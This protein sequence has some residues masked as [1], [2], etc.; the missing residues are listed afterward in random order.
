[1]RRLCSVPPLLAALSIRFLCLHFHFYGRA[2]WG[3]LTV[4]QWLKCH[5]QQ[6][7]GFLYWPSCMQ[8][9][10]HSIEAARTPSSLLPRNEM[11]R[12]SAALRPRGGA[13]HPPDGTVCV[14]LTLPR[15]VCASV[16]PA[17]YGSIC[18]HML[19]AKSRSGLPELIITFPWCTMQL[20]T[21]LALENWHCAKKGLFSQ[22]L[23]M[24][25]RPVHDRGTI[26]V[27]TTLVSYWFKILSGI[28]QKNDKS[29]NNGWT[30]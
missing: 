30:Q 11:K 4:V 12:C 16:F 22:W 9:V 13:V 23:V 17:I 10:P 7:L 26:Y 6:T 28:L 25:P 2:E 1:M 19:C 24:C 20:S 3:Y 21:V 8:L 29:W 18:I 14:C 15:F 5:L 27:K